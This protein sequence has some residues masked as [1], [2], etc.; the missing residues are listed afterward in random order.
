MRRHCITLAA[1]M[2]VSALT[3]TLTGFASSPGGGQGPTSTASASSSPITDPD[4]ARRDPNDPAAQKG[5][6]EK[7]QRAMPRRSCA[8]PTSSHRKKTLPRQGP[9][10]WCFEPTDPTKTPKAPDPAKIKHDQANPNPPTKLCSQKLGHT[11]YDRFH[12]CYESTGRLLNEDTGEVGTYIHYYVWATL[13]A[14]NHTWL[15]QVGVTATDMAPDLFEAAP[16]LAVSLACPQNRCEKPKVDKKRIFPDTYTY[17]ELPTSIPGDEK[18]RY[19]NPTAILTL[20]TDHGWPGSNSAN[21]LND[22]FNVR[23]DK[24]TYIGG[25]GCVF[26]MGNAAAAIFYIDY[27][28]PD[29][30]FGDYREVVKH[31]LYAIDVRDNLKHYGHIN[32]GNPLHR[33]DPVTRDENRRKACNPWREKASSLGL[34]CDEYPYASAEEGGTVSVRRSCAF[35]PQDQNSNH[36]NALE[37]ALY[38]PNR[39][40]PALKEND[41]Y[42]P[43]DPYWVWV[44]NAPSEIPTVK[45]C[46]QY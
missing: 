26:Y 27:N 40:L 33:A 35:L 41:K 14:K 32:Y 37:N 22:P 25:H 18:I 28:N 23:C 20:T 2:A 19:S 3:L 1:A 10:H 7:Q 6:L 30:K 17:Y 5:F 31:N 39:I 42:I 16:Y 12:A 29:P 46:D 43:G 21:P 38:K 13:S 15:M 8:T 45:Q 9:A 34:S 24:E 4:Q 44:L 11:N 36:G